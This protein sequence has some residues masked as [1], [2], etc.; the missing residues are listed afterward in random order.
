M[1]RFGTRTTRV[2]LLLVS[3][4]IIG[5]ALFVA[6]R[7]LYTAANRSRQKWTMASQREIATALEAWGT[8]H[9]PYPKL[10][11]VDQLRTYLEPAYIR[12][13]PQRDGW[14]NAFA[15]RAG[16]HGFII[17]SAGSDGRFDGDYVAIASSSKFNAISSFS[18]DL[19]YAN[20]N[21]VQYPEGI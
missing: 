17:A 5:L 3:S 8:D 12:E 13:L 18:E 10:T 21:F 2:V 11:S 1:T 15:V 6:T 16:G 4:A 7:E 20:G 14:G 9:G 19:I